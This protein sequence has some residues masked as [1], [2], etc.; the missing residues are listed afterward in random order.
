MHYK[1]RKRPSN[2]YRARPRTGWF[3]RLTADVAVLWSQMAY[4]YYPGQVVGVF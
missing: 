1:Y 3:D 2:C 4:D